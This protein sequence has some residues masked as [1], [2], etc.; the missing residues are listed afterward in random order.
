M[1]SE[2]IHEHTFDHDHRDHAVG[3]VA[4]LLDLAFGLLYTLLAI[5]LALVFFEARRGAGF[6]QMIRNATEP[7]YMP[8]KGLFAPTMF[9]G[10]PI[11]WSLIVAMLGYGLLH[12]GIRGLLRLI[13]RA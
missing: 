7:F 10:H 3:I 11:E 13:T 4:R 8:F 2:I 5:R 1:R 6:F 9:S 12:G